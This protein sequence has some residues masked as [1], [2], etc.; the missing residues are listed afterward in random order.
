MV[1]NLYS[2]GLVAESCWF[3]EF[4][5]YLKMKKNGMSDEEIKKEAVDNNCFNAPNEYRA[6]RIYG[7]IKRRVDTLDENAI[8]L[9]FNSDLSTQK[10][11]NL[12][13]I[14][15]NSRIF[16]EF[17][18]EVYRE[19]IIL[20]AEVIEASDINIFFKNKAT[21]SDEV[22]EWTEPTLKRL[23]GAFLTI[24]TDTNLLVNR[25]KKKVI[26]VPITDILFEKYLEANGETDIIKAIT[27][28]Y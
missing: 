23:K 8:S 11:I 2:S 20:G 6:K 9:F 12:T 5:D 13:C 10:L 18:N 24:L 1:A 7:Y 14:L 22:A 16:F 28:A 25:E 27:G 17:I 15:R 21:Q 3:L 4:K 26:K 19:K